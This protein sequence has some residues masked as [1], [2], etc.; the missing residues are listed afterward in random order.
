MSKNNS[1]RTSPKSRSP[2]R[3]EGK[4]DDS[5]LSKKAKSSSKNDS[6]EAKVK[7]IGAAAKER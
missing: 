5:K 1:R 2:E 3:N 4:P 7:V 6:K